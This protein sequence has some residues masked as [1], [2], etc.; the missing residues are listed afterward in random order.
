MANIL[1]NFLFAG[2]AASLVNSSQAAVGALARVEA[3]SR[4]INVGAVT[5]AAGV[6]LL[7]AGLIRVA[8][9]AIGV[10]AE[11]Q[12]LSTSFVSTLAAPLLNFTKGAALTKENL[13]SLR[14]SS[15]RLFI[16]AQ[17]AAVDTVAT[18]KEYVDVLQAALAVGQNVGLSQNQI[19]IITKRLVLAAGAYGIEFEKV[20]TSIAQIF[21][22]SVRVTNQLG[23]NLGLTTVEA[24]KLLKTSV[25]N[26]TLFDF[27]DAKTRQFAAT[28]KDVAN[29]FLNV[30]ASIADIFQVGGTAAIK[31]LFD[32]L[33]QELIKFRD[34]F[35]G[36]GDQF[37]KPA[38]QGIIN[39]IR[40]FLKDIIPSLKVLFSEVANLLSAIG[41]R[42]GIAA[43]TFK[44]IVTTLSTLVGLL[45]EA[46]SLRGVGGLIAGFAIV[47]LTVSRLIGLFIGIR[48]I[49]ASIG[50]IGLFN[51]LAT[52]VNPVA[53][54]AII[55]AQAEVATTTAAT[56]V[57][58]TALTAAQAASFPTAAG[59]TANQVTIAAAQAA[60]TAATEAQVVATTQLTT[61]QRGS[62][63]T[64]LAG[65]VAA[66]SRVAGIIGIVIGAI[67][68]LKIAYDTLSGS[69]EEAAKQIADLDKSL[70]KFN[71]TQAQAAADTNL[72]SVIAEFQNLSTQ[73]HKSIADQQRLAVI[74]N[75]LRDALGD[76]AL[77]ALKAGK[78]IDLI[79]GQGKLNQNLEDQIT[80]LKEFE[81]AVNTFTKNSSI[82]SLFGNIGVGEGAGAT[83]DQ[84]RHEQERQEAVQASKAKI[85]ELA[86]VLNLDLTPA[87]IENSEALEKALSAAVAKIDADE[88]QLEGQKLLVESIDQLVEGYVAARTSQTDALETSK[89]QAQ[90]QGV[91]NDLLIAQ[92]DGHI[93]AAKA[94][95]I[96]TLKSIDA[97]LRQVEA[98]R[99]L[100]NAII[101]TIGLYGVTADVKE[102]AAQT[103]V[104]DANTQIDKL[105]ARTA[106]LQNFVA[107]A[108]TPKARSG[109]GG[110]RGRDRD[111]LKDFLSLINNQ[112]GL[113]KKT[114][115]GL[116]KEA[117]RIIAA[118]TS[119]IRELADTGVIS[120]QQAFSLEEA[121]IDRG[122]AL[123]KNLTDIQLDLVRKARDL[124][125]IVASR[126]EIAGRRPIGKKG[127]LPGKDTRDR[128]TEEILKLSS[129]EIDLITKINDAA[130][131]A[132][133]QH[134]EAI[135]R[136]VEHRI[137]IRKLERQDLAAGIKTQADTLLT[138]KESLADFGL[139]SQRSLL[140]SKFDTAQAD[141]ERQRKEILTQLFPLTDDLL[142]EEL[143]D[144]VDRSG[145]QN[146]DDGRLAD[147]LIGAKGEGLKRLEEIIPKLNA[148]KEVMAALDKEASAKGAKPSASSGKSIAERVL[149]LN[150]ELA[151]L[152][153]ESTNAANKLK[154]VDEAL[155]ILN[156]TGV[157]DQDRIALQA[158][159]RELIAK[160]TDLQIKKESDLK[161]LD[162][163]ILG[164]KQQTIDFDLQRLDLLDQL[165][166]RQK[167]FGILTTSQANAQSAALIQQRLALLGDRRSNLQSQLATTS[168]NLGSDPDN[169]NLLSKQLALQG[170][171]NQLSVQFFEL[172][173]R[174][175]ELHSP[176]LALKDAFSQIGEATGNLPGSFSKLSGIFK[177]LSSLADAIASKQRPKPEDSILN[178]SKA[179][180]KAGNGFLNS[181]LKAA[182]AIIEAAKVFKSIVTGSDAGSSID[183]DSI[184]G[185]EDII[186]SQQVGAAKDEVKK[187]AKIS[188]ADIIRGVGSAV[189]G[190]LGGIANK[191]VGQA[192]AGFGQL[193]GLIPVAGPFIQAGLEIVGGIVS[194]FGARAKEK[195]HEMAVAI[196]TGIDQLKDAI[197]T[198]AIGLGQGI[199]E[200]QGKLEDARRQLSGRKGGKEELAKI[201][202]DTQAEIKR[203]REQ[204]RQVQDDF[205]AS[206]E[207]LRQPKALRD[208]IGQIQSINQQA[209]KFIKSFENPE[210]ALAAVKDAQ[211]FIHRSIQEI[212]DDIEATL[213]DLQTN[214]KDAVEKFAQ[215]Q[216]DILNEGR[217][218]PAVSEAESKKR[219]LIE[220][221][222]N[223]QKEKLDLEKQIDAEKTKLDYV[224]SRAKL[225]EK[226]ANLAERGAAALGQAASRI[227][228]AAAAMERAF[229]Q[230]G[231]FPQGT[232]A[233]TITLNLKVND[234]AVGSQQIGLDAIHHLDLAGHLSSNRAARF[235]PLG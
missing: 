175:F 186:N 39:G 64:G 100:N 29:N 235:N 134:T 153:T 25:E 74:T 76:V 46:I 163:E 165:V 211:E 180:E 233:S 224:N 194:F 81:S 145:V 65:G 193:A 61:L 21:T 229:A 12:R 55:A 221:E 213:K 210:D 152:S 91:F 42:S 176:M 23:R 36:T 120:F 125:G 1:V 50:T 84:I 181:T 133:G 68:G 75:I 69:A 151:D 227:S 150:R 60:A 114:A 34:T 87:T 104:F 195:T 105:K 10:S 95:A 110:G 14:A 231:F 47:Y 35:I 141:I 80:K 54:N 93:A 187:K 168:A 161:K 212:K 177:G 19:E 11:F 38:L 90:I 148:V 8:A 192:I 138:A 129:E 20:G 17:R 2:S 155:A 124:A 103:A 199:V 140:G 71:D 122:Q 157:T 99:D 179:V 147:R 49:L 43:F 109:G 108:V 52:G 53:I 118:R 121:L 58:T 30:K 200:L 32:F 126:T 174:A 204:A 146:T 185:D 169:A 6:G 208:V 3:Q 115:D 82:S 137:E 92:A 51:T 116:E 85:L 16:D 182:S 144:A 228:D 190:V 191:D 135:R 149:D 24:R 45:R 159:L 170:E 173:N 216:K 214:L 18:T 139:I 206:L 40:N 37:F 160:E 171:L 70:E 197:S 86:Q 123:Q 223:F 77:A 131:K 89:K 28:A 234:Q 178:A 219:R 112:L 26:G 127:K 189:S 232:N 101:A 226:I 119:I 222:R 207:L 83:D 164:I 9:S 56:T 59:Y 31:P 27:L 143:N 196:S 102:Q 230:M 67:I 162:I 183:L 156:K 130:I 111:E 97:T 136:N 78:N 94:K 113:L 4:S 117:T 41:E 132:E 106:L 107:G 62:T 96:E 66:F 88:K 209:K 172:K 218:D 217:I 201:E 33:N 220:L 167:E 205:R 15:T 166:A 22:G 79:A 48:N 184:G 188:A 203:L 98:Q 57:A 202:E 198:G 225:E 13:E 73:E 44:T 63:A 158:Q 215:D 154:A 142:V 128:T 7:A 5:A 72:R